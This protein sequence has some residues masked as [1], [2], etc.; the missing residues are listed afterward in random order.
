MIE[1]LSLDCARERR[2]LVAFVR[3]QLSEAGYARAVVGLSGGVD[4]SLVAALCAEALGPRN[5]LDM[6]MPYESSD[7]RSEEHARLVI[8]KFGLSYERFDITAMV[9]PLVE[10]Y[11]EL[12]AEGGVRKG[13]IMARCRM[14]VLYDQS[15][16][17]GGLVVGTSNRTETLL[18]YFTLHG[19]G[20]AAIKPIGH[21]F[22]CQVRALARHMGVPEQVIAKPPSADL[23]AGQTDEGELGFSY[24]QAD[25]ILYLL[26][27]RHVGPQEIA[28]GGFD[29]GVVE[30]VRRRVEAT[31]FERS[32]APVPSSAAIL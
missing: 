8:E 7:P 22:K 4:S 16:R 18:G 6:I 21:L 12:D 2:R 27:E 15:E 3:D 30:A 26:T 31:A 9:R 23:W 13:N 10:R 1:E 14:I 20:A 29:L 19:D 5:V 32:P 25:Q 11:P 28:A 17:F 24:D